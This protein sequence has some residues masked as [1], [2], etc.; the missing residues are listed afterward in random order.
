MKIYYSVQ[1]GHIHC[2]VF[3]QGAKCGDLCFRL[4]E[5]ADVRSNFFG[6]DVEFI[7]EGDGDG[8]R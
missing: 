4:S 8:T 1:G 5:W 7:Q 6:Q 2:R 3:T